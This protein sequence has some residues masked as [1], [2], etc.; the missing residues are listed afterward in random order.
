MNPIKL[1][2]WLRITTGAA[3]TVLAV[4]ASLFAYR[5]HVH[6]VCT[7]NLIRA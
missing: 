7:E 5:W 3:L 6:P 1:P 2:I 4:S